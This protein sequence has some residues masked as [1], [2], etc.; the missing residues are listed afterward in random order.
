MTESGRDGDPNGTEEALRQALRRLKHLRRTRYNGL[1]GG[2]M[3]AAIVSDMDN[4][5]ARLEARL[6]DKGLSEA[7]DD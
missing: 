6:E 4:E 5:I 7:K 2:T 3:I 1:D